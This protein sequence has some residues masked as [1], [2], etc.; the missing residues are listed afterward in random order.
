MLDNYFL[1]QGA[2]WSAEDGLRIDHDRVWEVTVAMLGEVLALQDRGSRADSNAYIERWTRWDERHEAIAGR[3][4]AV[5]RYRFLDARYAI[6]E[7]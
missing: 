1:E 2:L 4:R 7:D 6:L 3:I 5:E